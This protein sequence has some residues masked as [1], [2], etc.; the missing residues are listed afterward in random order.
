MCLFALASS[1]QLR[2]LLDDRKSYFITRNTQ[3]F[4]TTSQHW[5]KKCFSHLQSFS[6]LAQKLS[7]MIKVFDHQR[8]I[9]LSRAMT[10]SL[11]F[12]KKA[13]WVW[14][15]K[16]FIKKRTREKVYLWKHWTLNL[17]C[18][19]KKL[20]S[21]MSQN[22]YFKLPFFWNIVWFSPDITA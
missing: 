21:K 3:R 10:W 15:L 2:K 16:R 4:S 7:D 12:S 20:K 5:Q 9:N 6:Q 19:L 17:T 11:S 13:V 22:V 8:K 18:I 14:T 1:P